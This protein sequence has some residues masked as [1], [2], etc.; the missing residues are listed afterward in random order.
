MPLLAATEVES[1][2]NPVGIAHTSS[3]LPVCGLIS[4]LTASVGE[5]MS[6]RLGSYEG[7]GGVRRRGGRRKRVGRGDETFFYVT[8]GRRPKF[9]SELKISIRELSILMLPKNCEVEVNFTF[10]LMKLS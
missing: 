4:S 2:S 10:F 7:E 5:A 1:T 3:D 9:M 6:A 8:G